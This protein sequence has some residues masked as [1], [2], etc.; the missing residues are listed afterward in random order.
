MGDIFSSRSII[1]EKRK[2]QRS[3]WILALQD[4][5]N[6]QEDVI[7]KMSE[8]RSGD[9]EGQKLKL[10]TQKTELDRAMG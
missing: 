10:D 8:G 1:H 5:Q 6:Q 2:R 9:P 7:S 4:L 3:E